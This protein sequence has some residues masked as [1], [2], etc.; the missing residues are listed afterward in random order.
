MA[1]C[2]SCLL[3]HSSAHGA[4][5]KRAHWQLVWKDEF[6]GTQVDHE[7]WRIENAA[8]KKNNEQQ[9]YTP[10]DVYVERGQLVLRSRKIRKGGRPYT[11]G[12]VETRYRFAQAF[13]RFEIRAQLPS[14]QGI[15]PAIWMLPEDGS[16][17]PEIDIVELLGHEPRTVHMTHHWGAWPKVKRDHGTFKGPDF[18]KGFHTFTAEWSPDR[19]DWFIDGV[20]KHSSTYHI[21]QKPFYLILNTAVGGDW[22]GNPDESTVFPQYHRIDYV[23][24]Y[25]DRNATLSRLGLSAEHGR[26]VPEPREYAFSPKDSVV[27]TA[28]PDIGFRFSHWSGDIVGDANPLTLPMTE[29]HRIEA[30]FEVDPDAPTC[31]TLGKTV[32]ASSRESNKVSWENA[33][34]GNMSTRWG[35]QFKDPQWLS[36]DLGV[37]T[38]IRSIRLSWEEAFATVYDIQTSDNGYSWKTIHKQLNGK[39]SVETISGLHTKAR[40]VRLLTRK[41]ATKYGCSLWELEVYGPPRRSPMKFIPMDLEPIMIAPDDSSP[42]N[43]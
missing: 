1:C 25:A 17:P 40:Y 2:I 41:R 4:P 32:T 34:D 9:Y 28:V 30:H 37:P 29:S 33:V 12:L 21:P 20:K 3:L 42:V 10:E 39:G 26:I 11:S 19:M 31:L 23:R 43:E 24:I 16:W 38:D 8:L 7:K 27:L 35:S 13:G 5:R 15:W 14:G 18:S 6:N 22:P 36:I